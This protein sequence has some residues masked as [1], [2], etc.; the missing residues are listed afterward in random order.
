MLNKFLKSI[1]EFFS[2]LFAKKE[3]SSPLPIEASPPAQIEPPKEDP[4]DEVP[5]PLPEK[6]SVFSLALFP[7]GKD[8]RLRSEMIEFLDTKI[9]PTGFVEDDDL[10]KNPKRLFLAACKVMVGIREEGGPNKGKLVEWI[11][12]TYGNIVGEP[13]C[14]SAMQTGIA[15]AE[16]RT[17]VISPVIASEHCLTIHQKTPK[18]ARLQEPKKGAL[19]IWRHGN[20]QSGH[21]GA[22]VSVL[23]NGVRITYEGNTSSGSAINREG[24]GFYERQRAKGGVGNMKEL[25]FID[26]FPSHEV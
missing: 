10:I 24:D 26:P 19:I 25:G 5:V 14:A 11:Q 7:T 18:E 8:R 15:Y 22:I 6:L 4:A 12:D 1:G 20:T 23:A 17:G 3:S 2:K 21:I 9:F 13:W 16:T